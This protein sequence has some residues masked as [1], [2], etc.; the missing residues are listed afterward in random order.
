MKSVFKAEDFSD[1]PRLI[2]IKRKKKLRISLGIPT[3]NEEKTII[4]IIRIIK[5]DLIEKYPLIDELAIFDCGSVDRTVRCVRAENVKVYNVKD[6]LPRRGGYYQGKGEAL[7]KSLFCL[8]G[9]IIAWVDADIENFNNSFVLGL[10]G[11]LIY[12]DRFSYVKGFFKR[13]EKIGGKKK[14]TEGG[15]VSELVAKP[16][17]KILFPQLARIIEPLSGEHAG[18]RRILEKV[19]FHRGYGVEVSLLLDIEEMFGLDCIVQTDMYS[20]M[21]RHRKLSELVSSSSEIMRVFLA[22][23]G[24]L[25][26]AS[27]ERTP[28]INIPEYRKKFGKA[29][30]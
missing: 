30:I 23:A 3:L 16:L 27:L 12:Y 5:K 25:K 11:P 1:I 19:R 17:V 6:A 15:R 9:D 14:V 13:L 29:I 22:H 4:N 20:K 10:V 8:T 24:V 2:K 21:H 28:I 18:R 26:R 7:W